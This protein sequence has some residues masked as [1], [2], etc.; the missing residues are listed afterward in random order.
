MN[1]Q[2]GGNTLFLVEGCNNQTG[3]INWGDNFQEQDAGLRSFLD[4]LLDAPFCGKVVIT[5][6]VYPPS[7]SQLGSPDHWLGRYEYYRSSYSF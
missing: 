7:V 2:G 5:P 6:H 3:S 4:R 1:V